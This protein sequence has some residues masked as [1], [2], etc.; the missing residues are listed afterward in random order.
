M[1]SGSSIWRRSPILPWWSRRSPGWWGARAA[2]AAFLAALTTFLGARSVLLVVDNLEQLLA[3]AADLDALLAGDL[4]LTVLATSRE[5][6]PTAPG[7]GGRGAAP[8]GAR[9]GSCVLDRRQPDGDARHPIV[10]GACSGRGREL[11]AVA[12]QCGGRRRAEPPPGGAAPGGGAG[13]RPHP[14]VRAG[15]A[16]GADA[17]EPGP[18]PLGGAR[19][20]TPPS[21]AARHPRLELRPPDGAPAGPLPSPGVFAGGFTL[22]GAE[23][24][25]TGDVSGADDGAGDGLFTGAPSRRPTPGGAGRP[26]CWSL[27]ASCSQSTQSWTSRAT[28]CWRRCASSAWSNWRRPAKR[29][30]CGVGT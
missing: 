26:G 9:R 5:P 18:A 25:F 3:A 2:G 6:L 8:A 27:T 21:L 16:A 14:A 22:D 10:R 11:R 13:G 15:G 7:A 28:A 20:A 29:R 4:K 12:G 17:P 23:A 1:A 24:V 19:R 30:R